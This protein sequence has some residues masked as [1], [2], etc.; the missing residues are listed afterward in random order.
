MPLFSLKR[1]FFRYREQQQHHERYADRQ[2][3][4]ERV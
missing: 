4:H 1:Q 3:H 2:Q